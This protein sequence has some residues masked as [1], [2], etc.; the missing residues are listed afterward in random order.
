MKRSEAVEF[1][2]IYGGKF[3]SE[4]LGMPIK[5]VLDYIGMDEKQFK[6]ICEKFT[7]K[8][9]FKKNPDGSLMYDN[10]GDL[11]IVNYDNVKK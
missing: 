6:I 9:I 10:K 1:S 8:K 5:E 3:P 11:I 2:R 4:Y 7:N